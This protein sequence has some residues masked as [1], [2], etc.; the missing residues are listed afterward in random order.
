MELDELKNVWTILDKNLN[1]N[2]ILNSVIIKEILKTKAT[3]ALNLL[4]RFELFVTLIVLL[5]LPVLVY[6]YENNIKHTLL[7]DIL[8]YVS[9]AMVISGWITQ[10]YKLWWLF[11]IDETGVI[12]E[13]IRAIQKYNI[14]VRREKIIYACIIMPMY[15][16]L[17]LLSFNSLGTFSF[18]RWLSI[19][20]VITLGIL[21]SFWQYKKI[22]SANIKIITRSLEELKELEEE[23]E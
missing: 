13:N 8:I 22:Y 10:P 19:I 11:K 18:W 5:G 2:N 14:Y 15:L 7:F 17:L 6:I 3:K 20:T 12:C 16:V 9:V 23:K 1:N 4:I 21:L